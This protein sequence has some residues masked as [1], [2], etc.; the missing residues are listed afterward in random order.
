M[1][2]VTGDEGSLGTALMDK[3]KGDVE[4]RDIWNMDVRDYGQVKRVFEDVRPSLVYHLAAAKS[5]PAGE[6]DPWHTSITNIAGTWHVLRAAD[7]V[8]ARVVTAS[9]CKACDP[10][11]VY[12]ASKLVAERMTLSGGGWVA[13]FHNIRQS[14]GNVFE[15]WARVPERLPLPVT[16][17]RRYF[18]DMEDAVDLLLAVPKLPPGRYAV[19]PGFAV[20]MKDVAREAYPGRRLE[21]VPPRRGDRFAEPLHG[22]EE[23]VRMFGV[24]VMAIENPHDAVRPVAVAA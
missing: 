18:I 22:K 14:S 2:L 8:G 10:V 24:G 21:P 3:L 12:G 9:T 6:L 16:P 13:R 7:E 15:L 5:A 20:A 4:G 11:T 19:N 17:C 1:I 23:R